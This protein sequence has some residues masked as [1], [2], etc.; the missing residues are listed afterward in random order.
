MHK[1]YFLVPSF[2]QILNAEMTTTKDIDTYNG[3]SRVS[4]DPFQ[5][6]LATLVPVLSSRNIVIFH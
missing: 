2:G 4:S 5:K 3:L 6:V 1:P